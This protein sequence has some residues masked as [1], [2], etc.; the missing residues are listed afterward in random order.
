MPASKLMGCCKL[1]VSKQASVRHRGTSPL[2]SCSESQS[3]T[4][5]HHNEAGCVDE[6][7]N[8]VVDAAQACTPVGRLRRLCHT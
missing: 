3:S 6:G 7:V 1:P 8:G 5:K 4:D 2:C